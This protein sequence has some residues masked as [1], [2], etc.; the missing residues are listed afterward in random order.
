MFRFD[1]ELD[2]IREE[3]NAGCGEKKGR[4]VLRYV[5]YNV[6]EGNL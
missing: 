4:A 1:F 5:T 2:N 6:T 3:V